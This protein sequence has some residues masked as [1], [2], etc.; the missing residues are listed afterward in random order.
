MLK[1]KPAS[2]LWDHVYPT[3]KDI[4]AFH[5][6]SSLGIN[7]SQWQEFCLRIRKSLTMQNAL[8]KN[9]EYNHFG[10]NLA[11]PG[12]TAY[13]AA[14]TV[15]IFKTYFKLLY[16]AATIY[17]MRDVDTFP[18]SHPWEM[19]EMFDSIKHELRAYGGRDIDRH[20]P[21][22]KACNKIDWYIRCTMG[23]TIRGCYR[24]A[25][26]YINLLFIKDIAGIIVKALQDLHR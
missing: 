15:F 26:Y 8:T 13:L 3:E 23:A 4:Y 1:H 19:T 12:N 14:L 25:I 16:R 7:M 2:N 20:H 9:S 10:G 22:D 5:H 21:L 17:A 18:I 6:D 11:F 24:A